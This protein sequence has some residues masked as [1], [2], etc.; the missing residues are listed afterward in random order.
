MWKRD[1]L[2]ISLFY[3]ESINFM[4][5]TGYKF[6]INNAEIKIRKGVLFVTAGTTFQLHCVVIY[7]FGY[8]TKYLQYYDRNVAIAW[9]VLL[10]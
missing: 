2:L 3:I 7:I 5:E 4:I 8:I 1:I 9:L 10:L 6:V